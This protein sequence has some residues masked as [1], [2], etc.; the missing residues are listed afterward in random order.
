MRNIRRALVLGAALLATTFAVADC[1]YTD[2]RELTESA[3]GITTVIIDA[4]AGFLHVE[5][6]EGA[7][8]IAASGEACSSKQSRLDDIRL[9]SRRSGDRLYI[10]AEFPKMSWGWGNNEMRLDF[11]V[12]L[13]STVAV[14]IED[15]SG[16]LVIDSVAAAD[17]DD[18][19]GAITIS[20]SGDIEI[21]DGSGSIEV[22]KSTGSVRVDD[23]S[24]NIR[25]VETGGDVIIGSDGSGGI[26]ISGV[27]G[28]VRIGSDGSGNIRVDN[29]MGDFV[30]R[31]DGSGSIRHSDIS[32]RVDVP[33]D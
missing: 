10:T 31:S 2:D 23:G 6:R 27:R 20:Q 11:T 1:K 8:D 24:G 12:A 18:G 15:G 29:V 33:E 22:R 16:E 9:T 5:G 3:S 7:A 26:S 19:S 21:E 13:P 14:E 17:I 28:D 30:V 32:G 25:I 4:G